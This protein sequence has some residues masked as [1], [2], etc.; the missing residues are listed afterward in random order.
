MRDIVDLSAIPSRWAQDGD[1]HETVKSWAAAARAWR[2]HLTEEAN[3]PVAYYRYGE[4]LLHLGYFD[5]AEGA[6]TAA[7]QDG[8]TRAVALLRLGQLALAGNRAPEARK[9]LESAAEDASAPIDVRS[10]IFVHL[11]DMKAVSALTG[12]AER[13]GIAVLFS[14]PNLAASVMGKRPQAQ[15]GSAN[16]SY[17]F[18][19]RGFLKAIEAAGAEPIGL[20][21]P[22]CIANGPYFFDAEACVHLRFSPPDDPR[23]VKGATNILLFAW[24]FDELPNGRNSLH[25]F[26]N[27]KAMIER[28]DEVWM[29]S[30][31]GQRVISRI[32]HTDARYVPSP[33]LPG[34][35]PRFWTDGRF[36]RPAA[37][38]A[39]L[40]QVEFVP[41][42]VFPQRQA[43]AIAWATRQALTLPELVKK[44]SPNAKFFLTV[45]NP[46]DQRKN[47]RPLFEA[48]A[49]FAREKP[50]AILLVKASAHDFT[51]YGIN[52]LIFTHQL[53][54]Q[55]EVLEAFISRQI[56]ICNDKLTDDDLDR[57]YGL[58]DYYICSPIAEG[59]N[60][61]LLE[62]ML[63]GCIP[64]TPC[65][66]AMLD[67][68][69]PENAVVVPSRRK[70]PSEH[71]RSVYDL[72][73]CE[74]DMVETDDVLVALDAVWALTAEAKAGLRAQAVR[75]V[76]QQFGTEIVEKEWARLKAKL[77]QPAQNSP[78]SIDA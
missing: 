51:A 31:H 6:F 36:D 2:K 29:P 22:E 33:V 53:A 58:S 52:D 18:A 14:G 21:H 7:A 72:E 12:S 39:P 48:F 63:R 19:A 24:E 10:E 76:E 71:L 23:L 17:A 25:P 47:L 26:S 50:E 35:N 44:S 75:T 45:V 38:A 78:G 70:V 13:S 9:L 37:D 41:L 67:Y 5:D 46:H 28:F 60:L 64:V 57:L 56:W 66:T 3:D 49:S 73:T 68:I 77:A 65:H 40:P 55:D 8:K 30:R 1:R 62:A 16:Y 34:T 27:R 74:I 32:T 43:E 54:R 61:P 11:Q 20:P 59:Q 42:A 69:R 15:L 4:C